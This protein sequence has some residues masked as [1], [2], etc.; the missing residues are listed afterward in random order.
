MFEIPPGKGR[1]TIDCQTLGSR[2]LYIK[3]GDNDPQAVS[4]STRNTVTFNFD[5]LTETRVLIYA[6]NNTQANLSK[7]IRRAAY[8]NDDSVKLYGI[9]INIDMLDE[10]G[11]NTATPATSEGEVTIYDLSGRKITDR[12]KK[13]LYIVNGKKTIRQ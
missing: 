3:I 6:A 8:A 10:D 7:S 13:G 2:A 4:L 5:V 11:I 9:S 1:I 12:L